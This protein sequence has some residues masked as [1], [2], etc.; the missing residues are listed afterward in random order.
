MRKLL[1][2]FA[3]LAAVALCSTPAVVPLQPM[4]T[5]ES[6]IT[7][8]APAVVP[9]LVPAYVAP[10]FRAEGPNIPPF[11]WCPTCP[12]ETCVEWCWPWIICEVP[13]P[14]QPAQAVPKIQRPPA[15]MIAAAR[16]CQYIPPRK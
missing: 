13:C 2:L 3:L 6:A 11:P 8:P 14:P 10:I 9:A 4:P 5:L 12:A 16:S 7:V 1:L 15:S